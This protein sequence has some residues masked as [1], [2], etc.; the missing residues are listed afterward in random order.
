M[1]LAEQHPLRGYD[2]T[3]LASA[4]VLQAELAASGLTE[5]LFLSADTALN[6]V[7]RAEHLT[8]DDPNQHP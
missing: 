3:H 7:A 6:E 1:A 2:A 5:L 8:V 4:L